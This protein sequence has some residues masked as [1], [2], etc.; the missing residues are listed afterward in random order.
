ML[1]ATLMRLR[2]E[3]SVGDVDETL[4]RDS[5]SRMILSAC[6]RTVSDD[7]DEREMVDRE[8]VDEGVLSRESDSRSILSANDSMSADDTLERVIVVDHVLGSVDM[9]MVGQ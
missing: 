6:P 9:I 2:E 4:L 8:A 1:S 3:V 5:E 7:E